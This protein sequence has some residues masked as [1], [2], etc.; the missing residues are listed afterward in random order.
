M[1]KNMKNLLE[2]VLNDEQ[3]ELFKEQ[4][5]A[6]IAEAKREAKKEVEEEIRQEMSERYEHS[7][8]HLTEAL[9]KALTDAVQKNATETGH[10]LKRLK[11]ERSKLAKAI[12]ETRQDYKTK[13]SK[14]NVRITEAMN[15]L[16]GLFSN[17]LAEEI[18]K[19]R[20]ERKEYKD[21]KAKFAKKLKEARIKLEAETAKRINK[22]ESFV[23][24][25]M[26]KELAE[27]EEDKKELANKRV[28]LE[29]DAKKKIDEAREQFIKRSAQL[30]EDKVSKALAQQ[31]TKLKEDI[32]IA[33]ENS[34]G[35]AIFETFQSQ[36]MSTSLANGSLTKKLQNSLETT[37]KE[38]SEARAII[39]DQLTLVENTKRKAQIQESMTARNDKI[40]NLTRALPTDK[41]RVME[42]LLE[43]V[44][45]QKLDESFKKYLPAVIGSEDAVIKRKTNLNETKK[46]NNITEVTGNRPVKDIVEPETAEVI[47]LKR[48]AGLK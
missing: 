26:E 18:E 14:S 31:L 20:K 1:D 23:K 28:E 47:E 6:K 16:E 43:N 4:M 3:K 24:E 32:Q 34:L 8:A 27:F 39:N 5:R 42:A 12:K 36:F 9:D 29:R 22:L 44:Q 40:K 2:T 19:T 15:E 33:K 7:I 45:T 46:I 21:E 48:L 41:K 37:R 11:E 25:C 10:E 35:Q 30:V 17:H 38:L 13:L